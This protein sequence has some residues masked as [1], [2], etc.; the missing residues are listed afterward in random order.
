MRRGIAALAQCSENRSPQVVPCKTG[1]FGGSGPGCVLLTRRSPPIQQIR[2]SPFT[3]SKG[4]SK[5]ALSNLQ[6]NSGA[7]WRL[8]RALTV[9]GGGL[10][11]K[12]DIGRARAKR[13]SDRG[14]IPPSATTGPA[15]PPNR[16]R[17]DFLPEPRGSHRAL[18]AFELTSESVSPAPANSARSG[19]ANPRQ[20]VRSAR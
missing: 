7:P 8:P 5:S 14:T 9:R 2:H 3:S 18:L 19:V 12:R 17:R 15:N 20:F 13:F 1:C 6:G 16:L 4:P 11:R 10:P